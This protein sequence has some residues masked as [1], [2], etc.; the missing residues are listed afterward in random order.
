M[1]TSFNLVRDQ[2][3]HRAD[4]LLSLPVAARELVHWTSAEK[5]RG[6]IGM[7]SHHGRVGIRDLESCISCATFQLPVRST[8]R[9]FITFV[10]IGESF[11]L[12]HLPLQN[13]VRPFLDAILDASFQPLKEEVL[14]HSIEAPSYHPIAPCP[15]KPRHSRYRAPS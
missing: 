7:R 5:Y 2:S 10:Q 4:L 1:Q 13:A 6:H 15:S 8:D 14:R 9:I 3:F 12:R 11:V